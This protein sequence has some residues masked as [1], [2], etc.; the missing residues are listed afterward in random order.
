MKYLNQLLA[1]VARGEVVVTISASDE[2]LDHAAIAVELS[3]D[4]QHFR[5]RI[6]VVPEMVAE[7]SPEFMMST[8]NAAVSEFVQFQ[9]GE[10]DPGDY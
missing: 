2:H 5:R 8:M 7:V 10:R 3:S 4:S 6:L 9:S 1:M